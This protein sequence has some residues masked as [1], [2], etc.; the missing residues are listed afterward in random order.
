[1]PGKLFLHLFAFSFSISCIAQVAEPIHLTDITKASQVVNDSIFPEKNA[2]VDSTISISPNRKRIWIIAGINAAAYGGSIII[3]NNAWYKDFPR[4]S[5]HTFNDGR[6]W[7]Q[8]D[9]LGHVWGAYNASR[10]SAAM[11]KWAGIPDKK[12]AMIGGLTSI[13]YLTII[14]FLDAYSVKWGWSWAD[15]AAN[16]T[17]A[18]IFAGQQLGWKEQRIQMKFSFHTNRYGDPQLEQRADELF[19][20]SWQERI[21]KDYNGQ[22]HWL[23]ANIKSFFPSSRIPEWLNIAVGYGG[24]GMFGGFE[25]KWTDKLGNDISRLD[26]PRKRQFYLSPDIDLTKIKTKSKFL[27]TSFAVLNSFKIP[28]PTLM[29][30]SKG[31]ITAYAIYF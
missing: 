8:M 5:F 18:G 9:K 7:L 14:E 25:N 26:I 6:E 13:G 3:F 27:R 23:S 21:L 29:I 15:M 22:T 11:W 1:L 20:E 30:D 4:T 12:S 17:G 10:G 2:V 28:A 24:D 19:G 31:K 16:I